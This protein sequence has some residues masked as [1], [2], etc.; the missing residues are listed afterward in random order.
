MMNGVNKSL[1][2][3]PGL[4]SVARQRGSGLSVCVYS[5]LMSVILSF[6]K[7]RDKCRSNKNNLLSISYFFI[8]LHSCHCPPLSPLSHSSSFHSSSPLPLRGCS[9]STRSPPSQGPQVSQEVVTSSPTEA[10]TGRPLLY[11]SQG[12]QTGP[13]VLLVGDSVSGSSLGSG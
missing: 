7:R 10:W 5:W 2:S 1:F 8:Y 12:P 3:S 13:C 6:T 4:A 11:L 9:P